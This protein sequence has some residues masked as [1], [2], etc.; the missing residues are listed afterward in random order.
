MRIVSKELTGFYGLVIL[1]FVALVCGALLFGV[2]YM[3]ELIKHY[4]NMLPLTLKILISIVASLYILVLPW[5]NDPL[6]FLR[7]KFIRTG[8][9]WIR[10]DAKQ[11]GE[12]EPFFWQS[13]K[14]VN[15]VDVT[16]KLFSEDE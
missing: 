15:G 13:R 5:A 16:Q 6:F 7:K 1:V 2:S 11:K 4:T 12:M 3:E 8:K 10:D 9:V 14:S